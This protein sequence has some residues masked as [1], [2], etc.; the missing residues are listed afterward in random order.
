LT[1]GLI[2]WRATSF[3]A[4]TNALVGLDAVK[5]GIE[6]GVQ[7]VDAR[8][9]AEYT[10]ANPAGNTRGGGSFNEEKDL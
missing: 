6:D 4:T 8:S 7:F 3:K 1:I 2:R 9:P 10:G 5:Q